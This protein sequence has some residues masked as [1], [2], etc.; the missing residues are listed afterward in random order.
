[1]TNPE[2]ARIV[3]YLSEELLAEAE[4]LHVDLGVAAEAGLQAA[5]KTA[6]PAQLEALA[7]ERSA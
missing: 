6:R 5:I 3:L 1:M 4:R 2:K 7:V